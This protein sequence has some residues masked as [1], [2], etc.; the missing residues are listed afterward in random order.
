MAHAEPLEVPTVGGGGVVLG[1][2]MEQG[3]WSGGRGSSLGLS[4]RMCTGDPWVLSLTRW[5]QDGL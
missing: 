2:D 1:W 3:R 4:T 5:A